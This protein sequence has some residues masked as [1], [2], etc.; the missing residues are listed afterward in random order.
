MCESRLCRN[1]NWK[2]SVFYSWSDVKGTVANRASPSLR[3][4]LLE[5]MLHQSPLRCAIWVKFVRE[6]DRIGGG[7]KGKRTW[8]SGRWGRG[9]SWI[10]ML[11]KSQLLTL[12][13]NCGML[14]I[15]INCVGS[16]VL[17]W[18]TVLP[19]QRQHYLFISFFNH[20]YFL[21]QYFILKGMNWVFLKNFIIS[22]IF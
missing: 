21:G 9:R 18:E 17:A 4:G 2:W 16:I 12:T 5:I 13:L 10:D 7:E 3:G 11:N 19:V 14:V 22:L 15:I 8:G 1:Q 6:K 20:F